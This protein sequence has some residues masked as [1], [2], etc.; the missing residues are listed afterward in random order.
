MLVNRFIQN[1]TLYY[2]MLYERDGRVLPTCQSCVTSQFKEPVIN[3]RHHPL[4]FFSLPA[5]Q[6]WFRKPV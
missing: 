4:P 6:A 3:A 1:P 5:E 2:F